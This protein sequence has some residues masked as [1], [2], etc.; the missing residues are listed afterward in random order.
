MIVSIM[1]T[2]LVDERERL[3][4]NLSEQIELSKMTKSRIAREVGVHPNA[5][6][7]YMSGR[8]LPSIFVFKRL[9]I[10]LGCDYDDILGEPKD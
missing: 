10:V 8:S 7:S 5:I 1:H 9:C 4:K 3:A 2:R 6:F